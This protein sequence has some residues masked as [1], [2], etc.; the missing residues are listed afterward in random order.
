VCWQLVLSRASA[1]R[2][3]T[4]ELRLARVYQNVRG[5]L[6]GNLKRIAKYGWLDG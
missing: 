1:T 6:L 3:R 5:C 2:W 4:V